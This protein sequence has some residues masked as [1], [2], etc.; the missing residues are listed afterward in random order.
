MRIQIINVQMAPRT[1]AK[2][3]GCHRALE[4]KNVRSLHTDGPESPK[5]SFRIT[6]HVIRARVK[7]CGKCVRKSRKTIENLPKGQIQIGC[8]EKNRTTHPHPEHPF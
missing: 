8:R 7:I 1:N 3:F 4:K 2:P 6:R 5:F